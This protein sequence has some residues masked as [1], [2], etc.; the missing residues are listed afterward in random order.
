MLARLAA[1]LA[2]ALA[3]ALIPTA[4]APH[5]AHKWIMENPETAYCCGPKD[6]FI[7]PKGQISVGAGGWTF[8]FRNR[9]YRVPFG[10]G[11]IHTSIDSDFHACFIVEGDFDM[12]CF[13]RPT[14]GA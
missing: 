6:C 2:A 5:G 10:D 12:R 3:V 1:A 7:I 8:T 4:A 13:F 9:V 14:G 11:R